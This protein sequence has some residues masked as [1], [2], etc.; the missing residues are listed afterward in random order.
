MNKTILFSLTSAL[1]L[2][3]PAA[4]GATITVDDNRA[5]CPGAAFTSIQAAVAAAGAGDTIKVCPGT[6]P[7]QVR[8]DKKLKVEGTSIGNESLILIRPPAVVP[9]SNSLLGAGMAIAAIILVD[10]A[11]DVTLTNLTVDGQNNGLTG[12]TPDFVGI[13]YRNSSGKIDSVA[14]RNIRLGPGLE[15]C[16]SGDGIFVQSGNGQPAKVEVWNSSIHDYQKNGITA[17][18][19]GTDLTADGNSIM[20]AGPGQAVAQNGIQVAFGAK[21]KIENN[22]VQNHV[23]GTCTPGQDCFIATDL[24]IL[25]TGKMTIKKNNLGKSQT[26]IFLLTNDSDVS[27]NYISDSDTFDGVFVLGNDNKI[28]KNSIFNSDEAAIVVVGNSNSVSNNTINDTP[29]G[30]FQSA[31]NQRS[32]IKGNKFFNTEQ[33]TAVETPPG[34]EPVENT[35]QR[36]APSARR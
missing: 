11:D 33:N 28:E 24:L 23:F 34:T 13:Y 16:Q 19:A 14:V 21:G 1:A 36:P 10:G 2:L 20:G 25:D 7:E 30:V 32:K 35:R 18:E 31:S 9:N 15:G 3:A 12:C 6:Y 4:R 22:T 29:V 8:I 27:D 26:G 17:N 5:Q